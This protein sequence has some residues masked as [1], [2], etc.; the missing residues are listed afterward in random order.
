MIRR[1][2]AFVVG[3]V[4]LCAGCSASSAADT[5]PKV[6]SFLERD[7]AVASSTLDVVSGARL[8]PARVVGTV[9]LKSGDDRAGFVKRF[10]AWLS[11]QSDLGELNLAVEFPDGAF[12]L[13]QS[14]ADNPRTLAAYE[15]LRAKPGV[16]SVRLVTGNVV[17]GVAEPDAVFR[18]LDAAAS[19][20]DVKRVRGSG[21]L[22]VRRA[23]SFVALRG[24]A[25]PD[26]AAEQAVTAA[27]ASVKVDW[28]TVDMSAK[29]GV[30]VTLGGESDAD[31]R[32]AFDAARATGFSG[33]LVSH[34]PKLTLAS[35]EG[36]VFIPMGLTIA[37]LPG[38]RSV[39]I[40]PPATGAVVPV[41]RVDVAPGQSLIEVAQHMK[42]GVA[43][44]LKGVDLVISAEGKPRVQGGYKA[45]VDRATMV[46]RL[47]PNPRV[48]DVAWVEEILTVTAT[49]SD[50]PQVA[51]DI[52][53]L[54]WKERSLIE[55]VDPQ[56]GQRARFSST[57]TSRGEL[58][59][60][61]Y[62][63]SLAVLAAWD[64]SAS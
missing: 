20:A 53:Q 35:N 14:A 58:F 5:R 27:R 61:P 17:I 60:S 64:T 2:L 18:E 51:R 62:P 54:G 44:V 31:A 24:L 23:T 16:T 49:L 48:V 50:M 36:A 25:T 56:T 15:R 37:A 21:D 29:A 26:A 3:L 12:S 33:P 40:N 45:I 43:A 11:G 8:Q 42:T 57:T 38:V 30:L 34:G 13:T 39:A 9:A 55:L 32:P 10:D 52:R 47:L 4:L 1:L 7:A 46:E 19:D 59:R 63:Q 6:S 28:F 22:T 41:F